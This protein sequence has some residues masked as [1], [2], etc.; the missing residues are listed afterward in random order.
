M[1]G[2]IERDDFEHLHRLDGSARRAKP[3]PRRQT[4]EHQRFEILLRSTAGQAG[5]ARGEIEFLQRGL[6]AGAG[7]QGRAVRLDGKPK[8]RVRSHGQRI[9]RLA[10]DW[11]AGVAEHFDQPPTGE[12]AQ[13]ELDVLHVTRQIGHGQHRLSVDFA[14]E[15]QHFAVFGREQF[16]IAAAQSHVVLTQRD[17]P[18]DPP[19]ERARIPLLGFD[20]HG[21]IKI[22]RVDDQRRIELLRIGAREAGIAVRTPLHRRADAMAIAQIDVV[23]HA[24]LVAVIYDRRA[25]KRTQ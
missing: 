16:E 22:F 6:G 10:D 13:V 11:K 2:A 24:D 18:L 8:K 3:G 17:Q 23:A 7:S 1:I 9:G 4:D 21:F 5:P 15:G 19:Q 25:R 20:I 12:T 14:E